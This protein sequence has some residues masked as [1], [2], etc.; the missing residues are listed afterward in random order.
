MQTHDV[1]CTQQAKRGTAV[2]GCLRLHI[3][4]SLTCVINVT[5][6]VYLHLKN[7]ESGYLISNTLRLKI[8]A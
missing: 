7:P 5:L 1:K 3:N 4:Q 2:R 8:A 6:K